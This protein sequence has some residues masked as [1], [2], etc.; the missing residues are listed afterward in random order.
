MRL[1]G[2]ARPA[3]LTPDAVETGL[4]EDALAAELVKDLAPTWE[5][6]TEFDD[7]INAGG[8]DDTV[9]AL[10]G[11]DIV[12]G[13]AGNDTLNGGAGNDMIDGGAGADTLNGG[14]GND[15][16]RSGG[17]PDR[18]QGFDTLNGDDGDDRIPNPAGASPTRCWRPAVRG[19]VRGPVGA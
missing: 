7:V 5:R 15:V 10:G 9:N 17:T 18:V 8:G 3:E 13:D 2:D 19:P 16:L 12:N 6:H 14:D 4:D 11:N 1:L